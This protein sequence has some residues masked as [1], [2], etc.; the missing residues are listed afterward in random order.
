MTQG[1]AR[2]GRQGSAG[3]FTWLWMI[4]AVL[5]VAGLMVWLRVATEPTPVA[6]AEDPAAEGAA[7]GGLVTITLDDL[8]QDAGRFQGQEVRLADVRVASPMGAQSFW[9]E[10]PNGSPYL[11]RLRPEVIAGGFAIQRGAVVTVTGTIHAMSD[12]VLAAWQQEG[13]I[14]DEGQKAEAQFAVTFLEAREAVPGQ[15]AEPAGSQ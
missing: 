12:S 3:R 14:A 7:E 9:V 6:V 8:A 5:M 4:V 1:E 2:P 13:A 11:I 10:L 15:A